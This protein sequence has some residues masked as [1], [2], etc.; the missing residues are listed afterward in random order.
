MLSKLLYLPMRFPIVALRHLADMA[1]SDPVELLFTVVLQCL[2]FAILSRRFD[3]CSHALR[4]IAAVCTCA[5]GH[6]IHQGYCTCFC[7]QSIAPSH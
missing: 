1:I 4:S 2:A 5:A 3:L 7:L 6:C